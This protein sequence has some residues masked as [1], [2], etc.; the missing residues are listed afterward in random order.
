MALSLQFL[1]DCL[2]PFSQCLLPV[3]AYVSC[4]ESR[5]LIQLDVS[6]GLD[7]AAGGLVLNP[8]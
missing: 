5:P 7:V 1:L 8:R 2:V 4:Q 3:P 6:A